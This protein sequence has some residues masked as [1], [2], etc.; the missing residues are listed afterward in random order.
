M[1]KM[2]QDFWREAIMANERLRRTILSCGLRIEEVA[3]RLGCD[4]KTVDRWMDGHVPYRRNQHRIASLLGVDPGYLWPA[5]SPDE[6]RALCEAELLAIWP[7]RSLVPNSL[8]LDVF[9]RAE[10][11]IEVLVYAGFWLSEDPA[12]RRVL[13]TKSDQGVRVRVLVGD[14]TSEAVRMRGAEEGI[15]DAIAA[16]IENVLHNY[17]GV[18]DSPSA[19]FRL[20]ATTLY[21]SIFRGDE[22]M[23]VSTHIYG[24]PGHMTPLLQLRRVP[25]AELFSKYAESFERVWADAVPL[26]TGTGV[27]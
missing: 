24:Q 21:S 20:H 8:W 12:I 10:K 3:E 9:D 11:T 2:S 16:K 1:V 22:D 19:S 25:G 5:A 17:R 13:R 27:A 7:T 18:I 6:A 23:L 26:P 15:G 4:R 14:P